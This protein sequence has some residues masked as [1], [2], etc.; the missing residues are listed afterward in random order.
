MLKCHPSLLTTAVKGSNE[1]GTPP[2]DLSLLNPA[3]G[4]GVTPDRTC[5]SLRGRSIRNP[6]LPHENGCILLDEHTFMKGQ[7]KVNVS[8]LQRK[9]ALPD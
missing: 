6:L 3:K 1:G 8:A 9:A 2:T 5:T 7:A 4:L